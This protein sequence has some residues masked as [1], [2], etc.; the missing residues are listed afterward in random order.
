MGYLDGLALARKI[1][2]TY[3]LCSEQLSNQRHYD[4]GMRAVMA[5]LRTSGN[6]KKKH[7]DAPE[8]ALCLRAIVD[9]NLPKFLAPDVPLFKGIVDDLFPGIELEEV[10]YGTMHTC[11][12]DMCKKNILQPTDYFKTKVF[13]IYETMVVRH[14]FM[15]VGRPFAGKTNALRMLQETLTEMKIREPDNPKWQKTYA[16]VINPKSIPMGQLYG[17]FDPQTHEWSDGVLAI[18]YRNYAAEPPKVGNPEDFKWVWFD[19]PVDAIWIEN[20]NT[21]LDDNKKLC[22]MSGEMISMSDTMNMIFEPM[23]LEVASPATVS[24]VGVVYLEPHRMGWTPCVDSWIQRLSVKEGED[25]GRQWILTEEEGAQIL[26]LFMWIA[27]PAICYVKTAC[28]CRAP[29]VDQQLIV[30]CLRFIEYHIEEFLGDKPEE[31]G[32]KKKRKTRK[33]KNLHQRKSIQYSCFL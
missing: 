18:T 31:D 23:D 28:N 27:D 24:R 10:D 21:V 13:E 8:A 9:V 33:R 2:M 12:L 20:M 22:L 30:A 25:V 17:Q 11:L 4:Y 26:D 7:P 14:G 16:T 29:T 3:K 32:K 1:V 6:L 19:G 15:V 5:V